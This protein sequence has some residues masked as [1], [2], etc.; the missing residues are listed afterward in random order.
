MKQFYTY[1]HCK[2]D[3]EVFYV[4][5]GF[6]GRS[7]SHSG[8]NK[9]HQHITAKYGWARVEV[10]VFPRDTE[11]EAFADEIKWIQVLRNA[12]YKLANLSDG[13]EGPS[14][15]KRGPQ[16][17]E[18]VAKRVA[19]ITGLKRT[20]EVRALLSA[21]KIGNT[22]GKGKTRSAEARRKTA[23]ALLGRKLSPEHAA[24]IA[25]LRCGTKHS[26][27]T[28]AKMSAAHTGKIMSHRGKPWSVARRAA[29]IERSLSI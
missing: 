25:V 12:G 6:G 14:G 29:H 17:P 20:A 3:G 19:A 28:K 8:R 13:G 10:L 24:K 15:V 7:D 9:F 23:A 2:P 4:G 18:V 5:K 11:Q 22:H 26:A 27:E 21:Q 1:L 16:S